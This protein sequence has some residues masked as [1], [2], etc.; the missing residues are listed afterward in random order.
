[1][2]ELRYAI[3]QIGNYVTKLRSKGRFRNAGVFDDIMQHRRHQALMV[4]VHFSQD[5]GNS[6]GMDN[7][8]LAAAAALPF[9]CLFG[10]VIGTTYLFDL[11]VAQIL[12]QS[13]R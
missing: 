8:G 12:G 1:M 10:V 9:M 5:I 11:A 13:F 7:V 3:N 6:Q 4:E 2:S